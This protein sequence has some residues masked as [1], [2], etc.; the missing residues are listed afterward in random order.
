MKKGLKITLVVILILA[1]LGGCIGGWFIWRHNN[2]YLG[3]DQALQTALGDAGLTA[4][5]VFDIDTEFESN[6]YSAWY[7]VSFETHGM[8]YEYV[9]DAA[10]G[11][12]LNGY[13][14][15]EHAGG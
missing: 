13:A 7:E 4:A 15:P 11:S 12:I 3:K 8:E 9:I 6:R 1:V 5:E 10:N 2:K 14:E